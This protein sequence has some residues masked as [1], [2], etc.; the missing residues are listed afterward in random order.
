MRKFE[1]LS[2]P[3]TIISNL[4]GCTLRIVDFMA[5]KLYQYMKLEAPLPTSVL[6]C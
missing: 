2:N 4:T 3:A 1:F 5:K 6:P